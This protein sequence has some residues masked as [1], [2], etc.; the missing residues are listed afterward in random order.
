M[1]WK[2]DDHGYGLIA[3]TKRGSYSVS[4]NRRSGYADHGRLNFK[5]FF[6]PAKGRSRLPKIGQP[7]GLF[8]TIEQAQACCERHAR[9]EQ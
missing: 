2:D 6:Q 5:A 3:D 9:G 1:N 8:D 7:L 4:D